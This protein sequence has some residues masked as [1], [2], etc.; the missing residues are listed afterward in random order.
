MSSATVDYHCA[1]VVST[2]SAFSSDNL[3]PRK[4]DLLAKNRPMSHGRLTLIGGDITKRKRGLADPP[5]VMIC[6]SV[7][8]IEGNSLGRLW[9]GE[10]HDGLQ[11]FMS[12]YMY[13]AHVRIPSSECALFR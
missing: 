2:R 4:L 5:P 8:L 7:L 13:L 6:F 10:P 1:R 12:S 3:Q 9:C 11:V